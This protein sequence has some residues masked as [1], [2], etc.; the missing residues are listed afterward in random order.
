MTR[1]LSITSSSNDRLKTVRRRAP[2]FLVEGHRQVARALEAGAPVREL[3]VAPELFLGPRDAALVAS[4]ERRG[5][6]VVELGAAAFASIARNA[7]ADGLL[8]VVG[9]V[10]TSL[11][12]LRLGPRPLLVVGD[13]I[14]RPGNLGTI[15][16]TA[17]GAAA[18]AVLVT[19]RVADPF[20][21]EAV[22]GSVGTLFALPVAEASAE[23]AVS[24][25]QQRGIRIVVASPGAE[26]P[27][28]E[29]DYAGAVA[30]VMGSERHGVGRSWL[31]AADELASIPMPG[32]VDSL[33]VAVASGVVL[34]EA[35]RRRATGSAPASF[36]SGSQPT[37]GES[38]MYIGVG[39]LLGLV[40]LILL[41]VWI[42]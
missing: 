23:D 3:Y 37:K 32:P 40:L 31:E 35:A 34:F 42:F 7:R 39:S 11:A 4:A 36:T 1:R 12:A 6:R 9:R 30:I 16:R 13:A 17:A 26:L 2:V 10:P 5:A 27:Y 21:P 14:E 19:D 29:V 15:I 18:D 8:A 28:W 25:L 22:R 33:N 20:H 24:W 38:G 41:L